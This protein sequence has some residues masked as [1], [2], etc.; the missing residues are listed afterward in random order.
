M[1]KRGAFVAIFIMI[2]TSLV[3][4]SASV[5]T[6]QHDDI[7]HTIE[8]ITADS[9][10]ATLNVDGVYGGLFEQPSEPYN[11]KN[12]SGNGLKFV[13]KEASPPRLVGEFP[14]A[15]LLIGFEKTAS[16]G[17]RY[18]FTVDGNEHELYLVIQDYDTSTI[19][20]DGIMKKLNKQQVPPYSFYLTNQKLGDFIIILTHTSYVPVQGYENNATFLIF[21]ERNLTLECTENW[22]CSN[23]SS[24]SDGH[25]TRTCNEINNCGASNNKPSETQTCTTPPQPTPTP[26]C[27][28]ECNESGIKRCFNQSS[29]QICENYDS[30][31]CLEWGG[32]ILCPLADG[33]RDCKNNGGCYL[34]PVLPP[35]TKECENIGLR[36]NSKYCS[37]EYKLEN[38]K[39]NRA[40]CENNFECISNLCV[41]EKCGKETPLGLYVLIGIISVIVI[42]A[43]LLI[44][45]FKRS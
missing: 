26:N 31:S 27:K 16:M 18:N 23:W 6:L 24:C 37:F 3:S 25:Q 38:Q 17:E 20:I 19:Q 14:F 1:I 45:Y 7:N 34:P 44:T 10:T 12:F 33:K 43:I 5:F 13:L 8:L 21:Y 29:Y 4:A 15:N 35:I 11:L 28:D 30:D 22:S 2:V 41:E 42:L 40:K 32:K 39:I 36:E 9:T